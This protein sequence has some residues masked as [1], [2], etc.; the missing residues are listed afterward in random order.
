MERW[1]YGG[2]PSTAN[3]TTVGRRITGDGLTLYFSS[4]RPGGFSPANIE[5]GWATGKDGT[6][7][8]YSTSMSAIARRAQHSGASRSSC[9]KVSTANTAIT[10][11]CGRKMGIGCFLPATAPVAAA[12]STCMQA[13]AKMSRTT[14]TGKSRA[15]WDAKE[16]EGQTAR[17]STLAQTTTITDTCTSLLRKTAIPQILNSR[18]RTSTRKLQKRLLPRCCLTALLTLT[19]TSMPSTA[20]SGPDTRPAR[21]AY[22][23]LA[24]RKRR[25]GTPAC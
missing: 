1:Q 4:N 7:T 22:G 24:V 9:P 23:H 15:I 11:P 5:D 8:H 10:A 19:G 21:E 2:H 16:T 18:P 3:I 13:T 12:I 20:T 25:N 14:W 17:G 6:P